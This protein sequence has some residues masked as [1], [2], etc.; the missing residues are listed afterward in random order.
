MIERVAGLVA[1]VA[2]ASMVVPTE[3]SARGSG[4]GAGRAGGFAASRAVTFHGGFHRSGV[5]PFVPVRPV[6][7]HAAHVPAHIR[8]VGFGPL[9][10]HRHPFGRF[11]GDG[12]GFG[13]VVAGVN[14][15][16]GWP[17]AVSDVPAPA[18]PT[19][20]AAP[21]LAEPGLVYPEPIPAFRHVCRSVPQMVPSEQGGAREITITRCYLT[22]E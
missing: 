14:V 19:V 15:F 10:A 6:L 3:A 2:I 5:Q 22:Y 8:T 18:Q 20:P 21:G 12:F 9:G 7:P 1:V 17:E 13:Y 16:Y 4:F 11:Q